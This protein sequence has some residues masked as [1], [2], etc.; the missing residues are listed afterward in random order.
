[1]SPTEQ[2][3]IFEEFNRPQFTLAQ[4]DR[5]YA[6]GIEDT[7]DKVIELITQ[8]GYSI[9]LEEL[10]EFLESEKGWG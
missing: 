8:S 2:G 4:M 7:C 10:V 9:T 3:S 1:M 6:D 5:A